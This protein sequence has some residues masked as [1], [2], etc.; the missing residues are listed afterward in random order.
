MYLMF[1]VKRRETQM[2]ELK[3]S[4]FCK[5]TPIF[6]G[7][8]HG[9]PLVFSVIEG[10]N[11][12]RVFVDDAN[13]PTCA[14]VCP[15]AG[16]MYLGTTDTQDDFIKETC[17]FI[18]ESMLPKM[19]EKEMVLFAFSEEVRKKL[20]KHF[21]GKGVI[22]IQRRT[23]SFNRER[24]KANADMQRSLPEGYSVLRMS[25]KDLEEY[26]NN[27][28]LG[29]DPSKMIGYK[30]ISGEHNISQCVSIFVGGG[31]AEIDIFTD[32][33]FRGKGFAIACA[34]AFID[35]CVSNGIVPDWSCWPYRIESIN[36]A[37]KLG[38]DECSDMDAHFW[39]E[40]M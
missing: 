3:Q 39:A 17:D 6:K 2:I 35:E 1:T 26:S 31:H 33:N 21:Q 22:R 11:T 16:F 20:D 40:N 32:E 18:F 19:Q 30:V 7:I 38:F 15:E 23:F 27:S 28:R 36:L 24:Y 4:D 14:L 25:T 13:D 34:S 10:N 9:A 29:A 8:D 12:G 5:V 37:Q